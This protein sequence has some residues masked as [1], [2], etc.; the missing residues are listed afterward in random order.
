ML[1]RNYHDVEHSCVYIFP[2]E[3]LIS[4]E[5]VCDNVV[6]WRCVLVDRWLMVHSSAA[7]Q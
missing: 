1:V 4:C 3:T 6:H 2:L 7:M 5:N